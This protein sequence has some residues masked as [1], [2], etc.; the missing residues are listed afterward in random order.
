MIRP[1]LLTLKQTLLAAFTAAFCFGHVEHD[2]IKFKQERLQILTVAVRKITRLHLEYL[3]RL[4]LKKG[5][6]WVLLEVSPTLCSGF[7]I[8][9]FLRKL[10]ER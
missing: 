5:L 2:L 4:S 10:G 6:I 9:L 8:T 1:K 3:T 7:N